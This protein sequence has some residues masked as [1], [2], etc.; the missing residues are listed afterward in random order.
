MGRSTD[1]N[2]G[3]SH[4]NNN[5]NERPKNVGILA[6]EAYFP[7]T[8]VRQR[9]LEEFNGV[10]AGKYT[11][12]LGQ[13]AMAFTGDREDVNSIAL[14]CVA[15]L[16]E[17]YGIQYEQIGRLEVG[18]ETLVDKSKSTKTVLMSLFA[19]SGNHDVE[20]V[21][22]INACYGGTAALFNALAWVESSGWDG[23]YA[24][25]VT[26][27][28]AVYAKGA[29]RPTGGCG[30]VAMLIG[31]DAPLVIDSST[32]TTHSS[33]FW[34]FYKPDPYV[35]FP[36][37]DGQGSQAC[38]LGALDD[39]YERFSIKQMRKRKCGSFSIADMD[40]A[41]FH[42]P[43][44]KLVQ[45]SF[46]R[47]AFLDAR[48]NQDDPKY[49]KLAKW[50]NVPLE[51]TLTDRELDL[52]TRD[53]SKN[54]HSKMVEPACQ[55]SKK[56]GNCYTA[57][58]Y[59]NLAT[60]VDEVGADLA[61]S[62]TLVFSYGSGCMASMF[63]I[64]ARADS[65][66]DG[67]FSLQKMQQQLR[68]V[69]RLAQRE[70]KSASEYTYYMDVRAKF[71]GKKDISP[72][73]PL[74]D[75]RPGTFYLEKI[76]HL[77]QRIYARK[78]L[79]DVAAS[80]EL[81]PTSEAAVAT[82]TVPTLRGS[83]SV[84]VSGV[85]AV[86]PGHEHPQDAGSNLQKLLDGHNCLIQVSDD[87]KESLLARNIVVQK[88]GEQANISVT[89]HED[90]IQVASVA[91]TVD[92][93]RDYQIPG[94]I[95]RSMDQQ[96]QLAIAAGLEALKSAGLVTG[97]D[98]N[99]QLPE[100]LRDDVGVIFATSYPTMQATV[101]ELAQFY[102]NPEE[103]AY[104]RK[105]LFR[106]LVLANA[107]LA[108]ITGARGPNTQINSACAGATQAVGVAQ[109]WLRLGKCQR[110]LVVYADT[111]S[112]S[113]LFPWIG[114]GFRALGAASIASTVE[115]AALPFD[116]RRNGMIVGSGATGLVLESTP[117]SKGPS[118]INGGH[119]VQL[120]ASHFSNSA[121]H[122]ASLDVKHVTAEFVRFFVDIENRF[123]IT[124]KEFAT[125]GVYYSHETFTNASPTAS[126][127]YAE[128]TALRAALGP[129]LFPHLLLANTK[130]FTGHAMAVSFEDVTAVHGLR[131]QVVPPVVN[132]EQSDANLGG[133]LKV[134]TGG[135]YPH[136]YALRFAAGFG[137]Q[138]AF[139]LYAV[140]Q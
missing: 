72:T 63:A 10:P 127:A 122:G 3:I 55:S 90:C 140:C 24:L 4:H 1:M 84:L 136:K 28:I 46:S 39:C 58:V 109:D 98:G 103:F 36:T 118:V 102:N 132:F 96:T 131:H 33:H 130:G 32:R 78:P 12:G 77:Y 49:E 134:S 45:K 85:S 86:L 133:V 80:T 107:Q 66:H 94:A 50:M 88:K 14:T 125:N 135:R 60:L 44:N 15:Q 138:L 23:R 67:R 31:A 65:E 47:L 124:R 22:T 20:G 87:M 110:V 43:Y 53:L 76:D 6:M 57:S 26:A 68:L 81:A 16:M 37:V 35:E 62:K 73:Q 117:S 7:A 97:V 40:H 19:D 112:S 52:A 121:Y 120:L 126:C 30:A 111:A 93:E 21:S 5:T 104:D 34:D 9:D 59:M 89:K 116:A 119:H 99:W 128:I 13:E 108:Q 101:Q 69:D 42:S 83:G 100:N 8:Y 27:D 137:S 48:R 105:F 106:V 54:L 41:V 18:T 139:T 25:V 56:L 64:H 129:E 113:E 71:H 79:V 70:A 61:G 91:H 29:A 51:S 123:G 11:I 95:A 74:S 75:L 114:G 17:K 82:D 92:L 38:Y 2:G 115:Q